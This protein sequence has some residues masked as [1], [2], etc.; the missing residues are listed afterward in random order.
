MTDGNPK[1]GVAVGGAYNTF[2][3]N[4]IGGYVNAVRLLDNCPGN[5]FDTNYYQGND[6]N[7]SG[8]GQ[9]IGNDV[10][11]GRAKLD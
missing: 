11:T 5:C 10:S 3:R 2:C 9:P 7:M 6:L 1:A 8:A 4:R